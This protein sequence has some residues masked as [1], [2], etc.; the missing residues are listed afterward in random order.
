VETPDGAWWIV[1]LGTRHWPRSGSNFH[2]LGRETF[3][4]P[5]SWIDGWPVVNAGKPIGLEMPADGL[6]VADPPADPDPA[7]EWVSLR[8]PAVV[9]TSTRP[10]WFRLTGNP[11][12]LDDPAAPA[13]VGRRLTA[14]SFCARV[15]LEFSPRSP[16]DQAAFSLF[17]SERFHAE[18]GIRQAPAGAECFVRQRAGDLAATIHSA[19]CSSPRLHLE[20]SGDWHTITFRAGPDAGA[21]PVLATAERRFFCTEIAEGWT[22]C[23]LAFHASSRSA[24]APHADFGEFV[25]EETAP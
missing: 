10:D 14:P 15:V 18:I 11:S 12:T 19:P 1:F 8:A 13:F 6:P 2:H 9:D 23:F 20:I 17:L 24:D 4:A 25:V 22:G 16:G 7:H 3:L 5:V 21:L